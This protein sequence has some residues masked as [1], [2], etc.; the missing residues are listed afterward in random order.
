[1]TRRVAILGA[2][3]IGIEAAL[4]ARERGWEFTVYEATSSAAGHL[5]EWGHV[6][7]FTPWAMNVSPRVRSAL[8]DAAPSGSEL[9]L[10]RDLAERVL[11]PVAAALG[12]RLRLGTRV[13][14]VGRSGLLK[15]EEIASASRRARPFRLLV[16]GP[17]EV[18]RVT[19]A[20]AVLDCTGTWGEPNALGDGGIRAPG[21]TTLGD[22]IDRWLPDFDCESS[23]WAGRRILLTGSGHSAQTAAVALAEL[24]RSAPGTRVTWAVRGGDRSFGAGRGDS[25]PARASLNREAAALGAG[26][27]DAVDVQFGVVTEGLSSR[28]G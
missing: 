11:E 12:D 13:L 3:P 7:L 28:D 20:D 26:A 14:A 25:L 19:E 21:E 5:R 24:A 27:S 18:E 15:H 10:G 17:D 23:S 9:P 2:G 4:A 1:M 22:R 6:R 16:R 8:G